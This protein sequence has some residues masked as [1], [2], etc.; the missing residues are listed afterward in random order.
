MSALPFLVML[1]ALFVIVFNFQTV[2]TQSRR[3]VA[4][5]T[6]SRQ[7]SKRQAGQI[8]TVVVRKRGP[9]RII[10]PSAWRRSSARVIPSKQAWRPTRTTNERGRQLAKAASLLALRL[11]ALLQRP[12]TPKARQ[13]HGGCCTVRFFILGCPTLRS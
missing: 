10:N 6:S 5:F 11:C 9:A 13:G 2:L 7:A 12:F 1:A 4:Y 3:A 8:Q